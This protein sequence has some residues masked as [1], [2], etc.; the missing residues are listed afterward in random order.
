MSSMGGGWIFCQIAQYSIR[1][2]T[3]EMT[4]FFFRCLIIG[5]DALIRAQITITITDHGSDVNI[6]FLSWFCV[7]YILKHLK[8]KSCDLFISVTRV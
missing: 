2:L 5:H 7:C 1:F 3:I 8:D 4:G 6:L